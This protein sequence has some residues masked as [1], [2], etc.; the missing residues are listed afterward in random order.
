MFLAKR[1]LSGEGH[2]TLVLVCD[3]IPSIRENSEGGVGNE[4]RVREG[5]GGV[6]REQMSK[7]WDVLAVDP[8][9]VGLRVEQRAAARLVGHTL[10]M[11]Y[12]IDQ[13]KYSFSHLVS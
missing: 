3:D 12:E 5:L 8:K 1:V 10:V 6:V 4:D 9:A 7:V 13:G 11:L 2:A